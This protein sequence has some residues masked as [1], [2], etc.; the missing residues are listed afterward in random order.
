KY[1]QLRHL[2]IYCISSQFES[3]DFLNMISFL[4]AC[5]VLE[6]FFLSVGQQCYA[7]LESTSQKPDVD[8]WHIKKAPG[9]RHDKLKKATITGI[10]SSKSLI[11]LIC[12]ILENCSS[13]ECLV[14]DTTNGYDNSGICRNM[15]RRAVMEALQGVKAIERHVEWKVPSTV[16]FKVLKPCDRCH[17][18]KL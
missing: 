12:Q 10:S 17:M 8:S 3:F 13:L 2:K 14:L 18:S 1:L 6:T 15:D 5:P 4:E 11:E 7:M 9:F 16:I